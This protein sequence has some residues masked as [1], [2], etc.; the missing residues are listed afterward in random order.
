MQI[1][2]SYLK[3]V[4]IISVQFINADAHKNSIIKIFINADAHKLN[5]RNEQINGQRG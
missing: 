4:Y 5:S 3:G 2:L 1:C